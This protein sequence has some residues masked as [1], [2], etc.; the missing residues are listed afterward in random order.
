MSDPSTYQAFQRS[1]REHENRIALITKS[2]QLTYRELELASREAALF[3]LESKV[4]RGD[5]I[6]LWGVN[7]IEWIIAALAIQAVGGVLVPIGTRLRGREVAGLRVTR[8]DIPVGCI[9]GYYPECNP[10]IPLWHHAEESMVPAAKAIS[11][12]LSRTEAA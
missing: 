11:I 9:A 1:V 12:T 6:A 4:E 3:L 5:R 8:Y 10:L 2:A 7:S